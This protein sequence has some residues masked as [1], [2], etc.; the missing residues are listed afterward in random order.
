MQVEGLAHPQSG[1]DR[2]PGDRGH[3]GPS[4]SIV[5]LG[6]YSPS[7]NE[8]IDPY[9]SGGKVILLISEAGT[10]KSSLVVEFVDRHADEA[11]IHVGY[12]DDLLTPQPL[13]PVWDLAR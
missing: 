6:S 2:G 8:I 7:S 4:V 1:L 10:G 3:F 12:C 9:S 13:G 5:R 11:H